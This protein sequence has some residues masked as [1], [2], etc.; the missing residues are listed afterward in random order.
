MEGVHFLHAFLFG[1]CCLGLLMAQTAT[2]ATTFSNCD[3]R[4]HYFNTA[5]SECNAL[6]TCKGF[7]VVSQFPT[8]TSDRECIVVPDGERI[9]CY[10]ESTIFQRLGVDV[11]IF[12]ST[13]STKP[14]VLRNAELGIVLSHNGKD[15]WAIVSGGVELVRIAGDANTL[16]SNV[17]K[18][19]I[20]IRNPNDGSYTAD[21][22]AN[23]ACVPRCNPNADPC[24]FRFMDES[25][26]RQQVRQCLN[27]IVID[28]LTMR[29]TLR[30]LEQGV[31]AFYSFANIAA[32][33]EASDA[34]LHPELQECGFFVHPSKVHIGEEMTRMITEL[35]N[36]ADA[37]N[38]GTTTEIELANYREPARM[39]HRQL[40]EKFGELQDSHTL[41]TPPFWGFAVIG[42]SFRIIKD[43]TAKELTVYLPTGN[44]DNSEYVVHTVGGKDVIEW[45]REQAEFTVSGYRGQGVRFNQF[46]SS[47][48]QGGFSGVQAAQDF[49]AP[50]LDVGLAI[51][52]QDSNGTQFE[53]NIPV[54]IQ[55]QGSMA[56]WIGPVIQEFY[57]GKFTDSSATTEAI[58]E[59]QPA[60]LEP[61]RRRRQDANQDVSEEE[62][63]IIEKH[64]KRLKNKNKKQDDLSHIEKNKLLVEQFLEEKSGEEEASYVNISVPSKPV[65]KEMLEEL[66]R[67]RRA[68]PSESIDDVTFVSES[69]IEGY[70]FCLHAKHIEPSKS[71]IIF[72]LTTFA[73]N[74]GD[75][76][77]ISADF[78]Q[79]LTR[80]LN[81]AEANNVDRLLLDMSANG[82]GYIDL[83]YHALSLFKGA[84]TVKDLCD[85]T[86]FRVGDVL[87][88]FIE[89][90]GRGINGIITMESSHSFTTT[91]QV[92]ETFHTGI[93]EF[94][95]ATLPLFGVSLLD[96]VEVNN[97]LD[98]LRKETNVASAV[99]FVYTFLRDRLFLQEDIRELFVGRDSGVPHVLLRDGKTI[100]ENLKDL[101]WGGISAQYSKLNRE[102]GCLPVG[103][104]FA[105]SLALHQRI[106]RQFPDIAILTD[107]TCGSACSLFSTNLLFSP[108][109]TVFSFGGV[110]TTGDDIGM[111]L[112]SFGGANVYEWDQIWRNIAIAREAVAFADL[113]TKENIDTKAEDITF[114]LPTPATTRFAFHMILNRHLGDNALPREWYNIPAH[115]QFG[116]WEGVADYSANT[117]G[118]IRL[119]ASVLDEGS[120]DAVRE[121]PQFYD[122]KCTISRADEFGFTTTTTSTAAT[123]TTTTTTSHAVPGSIP[124][125]TTTT[126][127]TTTG[128]SHTTTGN[129]GTG[130]SATEIL[131][132]DP[133]II[134]VSVGGFVLVAI[135]VGVA[136]HLHFKKR[137]MAGAELRS[138]LMSD[139][140][141]TF[142][143]D[144][145][146]AEEL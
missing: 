144:N 43:A 97:A 13:P 3:S 90:V 77:L 74:S 26:S 83:M 46:I 100:L 106:H 36:N 73:P 65:E 34:S 93:G 2:A 82:G 145:V 1:L 15:H 140:D 29:S 89:D 68:D 42:L 47:L 8:P 139:Q 111:D 104:D 38:D 72:K 21:T 110:P 115:K 87:R 142:L 7:E 48:H 98:V 109:I 132:S 50:E 124:H 17:E 121:Q 28:G 16:P 52:V 131:A 114:N 62:A 11:G 102:L 59:E 69:G 108:N 126:T 30:T 133:F 56:T 88:R 78:N 86:L 81:Y 40:A 91:Q 61:S 116:I 37:D 41:Y 18:F 19:V 31:S 137:K 44:E 80:C 122:A 67:L 55:L 10:M 51:S 118:F 71:A 128:Q 22:T 9:D 134:G 113:F 12:S 70:A 92:L 95:K 105:S 64:K 14:V 63:L 4:T 45:L 103:F 94:H 85:P 129:G 141:N 39:F 130:R 143:Y 107:G 5:N 35:D 136:V 27:S 33:S 79:L 112:S 60:T 138:T 99:T 96:A 119:Y 117:A 57:N 135:L 146:D 120:W 123:T 25:P 53:G 58:P 125:D 84:F 101:N 23:M 76:V 127:T 6:K 75:L 54:N 32:D 49:L 24:C 66:Q 20:E